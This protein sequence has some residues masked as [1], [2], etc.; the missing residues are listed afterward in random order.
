MHI[1]SSSQL[2]ARE[3]TLTRSKQATSVRVALSAAAGDIPALRRSIAQCW[4]LEHQLQRIRQDMQQYSRQVNTPVRT[5]P[6]IVDGCRVALRHSQSVRLVR[7]STTL[8]TNSLRGCVGID[9]DLG[10]ALHNSPLMGIV[11][12][13]T[14]YGSKTYQIVRILPDVGLNHLHNHSKDATGHSA[15]I[16]TT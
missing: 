11:S 1:K 2:M 16:N 10:R 4:E 13:A 14:A 6:T 12:V 15:D 5:A 3:R 8:P 7:F 9:S